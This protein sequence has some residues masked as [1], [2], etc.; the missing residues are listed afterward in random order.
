MA[1]PEFWRRLER[2]EELQ[3]LRCA[4]FLT[5]AQVGLVVV[6]AGMSV[7]QWWCAFRVR[8]YSGMLDARAFAV[9][10]RGCEKQRRV[11]KV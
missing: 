5:A 3:S 2:A 10:H 7:M 11:V 8:E 9:E 4:S 1:E 6:F